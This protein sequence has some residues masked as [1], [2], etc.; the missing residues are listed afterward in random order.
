MMM[1]SKNQSSS[2]VHDNDDNANADAD[3][4]HLVPL[5][6][7]LPTNTEHIT[8][9]WTDSGPDRD[10]ITSTLVHRDADTDIII[11][12]H[13]TTPLTLTYADKDHKAVGKDDAG[14]LIDS[15]AVIDAVNTIVGDCGNGGDGSSGNGGDEGGDGSNGNGD[16]EVALAATTVSKP[17]CL[18]D[19]SSLTEQASSLRRATAMRYPYQ[20]I[21]D[22]PYLS[23][24]HPLNTLTPSPL[25]HPLPSSPPPLTLLTFSPSPP[26]DLPMT[27][28]VV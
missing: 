4:N 10:L 21:E 13:I 20:S 11:A 6:S 16:L 28:P 24:D 1:V 19:P 7:T 8:L 23:Y 2:L 17:S 12:N 27:V 15:K 3:T 26:L 5:T 18:I 22:T 25:T 14:D 9:P